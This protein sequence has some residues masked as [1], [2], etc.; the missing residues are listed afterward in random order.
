MT[1][2]QLLA[3]MPLAKAR[4]N[5]LPSL[6][7]AMAEFKINTVARQAAFLGT[8][9]AETGQLS[10]F[11]EGLSYSAERLMAVWPTRF[12]TFSQAQRYARNPEALANYVYANRGGNGDEASGDGW[13]FRGAGAIQLT[14]RA[15]HAACARAFGIPVDQ[16][17]DWLRTV[18][19]AFRSAGW[20]WRTN[21]V[22]TW[23]DAG[24][25]DGVC[26][27]VNI[28]RKTNRVGDA[29]GYDARLAMRN[30]SLKVL[31]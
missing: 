18:P 17:G 13:R 1:E 8:I 21:N 2:N 9:G 20:F 16:M 28:G 3:I 26:D 12:T 22:N 7:A 11:S 25:F 23:A 5:A 14:F 4:L 10:S 24:D 27:V 19:G 29:I 6:N 15:N 30:A 31:A